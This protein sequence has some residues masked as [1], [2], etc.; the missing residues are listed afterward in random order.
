MPLSK[1]REKSCCDHKKIETYWNL[2]TIT[3]HTGAKCSKKFS[4][5]SHFFAFYSQ[6]IVLFCSGRQ[7]VICSQGYSQTQQSLCHPNFRTQTLDENL[8]SF[9]CWKSFF[10][11]YSQKTHFG[12]S[13]RQGVICS[14]G[15]SQ[16]QQS[17]C[18]P[19]FRTQTLDENLKSFFC[20]FLKSHFLRF[21]AKKR[22]F[23]AQEGRVFYLARATTK[24][25]S[26]YVTQ[27]SEHKL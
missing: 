8:K 26:R 13:G 9:F 18:H 7:G 22:V 11:F 27:T 3:S 19:N 15:Y 17:L 20:L 5:K 1:Y 16:I 12:V 14:Q 4:G 2:D 24:F 10:A 23:W 25:S 21:I 6:K